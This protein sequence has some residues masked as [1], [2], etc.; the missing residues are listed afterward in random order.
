LR[1]MK[2]D[3]DHVDWCIFFKMPTWQIAYIE[4]YQHQQVGSEQVQDENAYRK[5][6]AIFIKQW[7][8]QKWN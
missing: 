2:N 3:C 4:N 5:I 8:I 6:N 1:K 7:T